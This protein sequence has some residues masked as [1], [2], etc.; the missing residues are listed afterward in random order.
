MKTFFKKIN[1]FE[2]HQYLIISYGFKYKEDIS[3]F[4]NAF[5]VEL[6]FYNNLMLQILPKEINNKKLII[7]ICNYND[8]Y[9]LSFIK[10]W[11]IKELNF[12]DSRTEKIDISEIN[13]KA[14]RV[15]FSK[16]FWNI[17]NIKF[18]SNNF[19]VITYASK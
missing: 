10:E 7:N 12:Y 8:N 15:F 13:I 4:I 11:N 6:F 2:F 3:E 18:K 9:D 5:N 16:N 14:D 19:N 1:Y 17:K